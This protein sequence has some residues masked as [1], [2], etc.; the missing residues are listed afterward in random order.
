MWIP[1]CVLDGLYSAA[2]LGFEER[3]LY[4]LVQCLKPA[5]IKELIAKSSLSRYKAIRS[6]EALVSAGWLK[7]VKEGRGM[8]PVA[9][10]PAAYQGKMAADLNA[11]FS[12]VRY[13]G[14]FLMKCIVLFW[15]CC[16][17]WVENARP[18]FLANPLTGEPLEY[19][20]YLPNE[21]VAFEY[22]GDQHYA[23]TEVYR[24]EAGVRQAQSHDLMKLALSISNGVTLVTVTRGDL[25]LEGIRRHLPGHLRLNDVDLDGPYAK[26][27][28]K[29]CLMYRK[30]VERQVKGRAGSDQGQKHEFATLSTTSSETSPSSRPLAKQSHARE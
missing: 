12:M 2:E 29:L 9:L 5:S 4:I 14:E 28:D 11:R 25:S 1:K 20:L 10:I 13:K 26:A 18:G 7:L 22:N 24:C 30:K 27:L 3:A 17:L 16:D 6:C 19:D 23:T 21:A 15:V 8:R